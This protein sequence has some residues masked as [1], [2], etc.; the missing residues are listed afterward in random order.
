MAEKTYNAFVHV[1]A[2]IDIATGEGRLRY[3]LPSQMR[4]GTS[5]QASAPP[6]DDQVRLVLKDVTGKE[7]GRVR[8][9]LRF[10]AC[11][12]GEKPHRALIQQDLEVT[13][14][15][16]EIDL[17]FQGKVVDVFRPE[18][19][20][21]VDQQF[22]ETA[23][24]GLPLSGDPN[25]LTLGTSKIEPRRG[26]SFMVQARPDNSDAWQTLSIGKPSP[27]FI[28]DKNQFPGA[29]SVEVRVTQN[30]GFQSRIVDHRTIKLD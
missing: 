12:D 18:A 26:V 5:G 10:E 29:S 11:D 2:S 23:T 4:T 28:V 27:D 9:D 24:F 17:E 1:V 21:P 30:A 14:A 16:A 15:L 20:G 8:P 7:I 13:S 19:A 6:D 3:V 22:R 25:K